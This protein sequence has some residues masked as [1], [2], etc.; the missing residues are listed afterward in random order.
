VGATESLLKPV[1]PE[2]LLYHVKRLL[3]AVSSHS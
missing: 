3:A 2:D 1:Y